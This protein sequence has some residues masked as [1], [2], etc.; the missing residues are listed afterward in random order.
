MP[1]VYWVAAK[2]LSSSSYIGE[3]ILIARYAHCGNLIL[4][5]SGNTV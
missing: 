3:I 1:M 4:F 5:L 2:E